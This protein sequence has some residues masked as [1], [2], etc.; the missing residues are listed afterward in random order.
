MKT[1]II[2][3]ITHKNPIPD[4]IDKVA[5]RVWSL[6]GVDDA[7][8]ALDD[9][10]KFLDE[11]PK[12]EQPPEP[13]QWC[14][15]CGEGVTDF[16]CGKRGPCAYGFERPGQAI[17]PTHTVCAYPECKCPTENP[18]LQ[19]LPAPSAAGERAGKSVEREESFWRSEMLSGD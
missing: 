16:C 1:K 18:C 7:D 11:E 8:A 9:F 19:G 2:L 4:L 10:V 14:E 5:N 12:L 15:R 3:T 17:E 13:L 6:Q